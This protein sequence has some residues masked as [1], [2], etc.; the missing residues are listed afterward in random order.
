MI[1]FLAIFALISV[2]GYV[3]CSPT[4]KPLGLPLFSLCKI[5]PEGSTS[6]SVV[7]SI[8]CFDNHFIDVSILQIVSIIARLVKTKPLR[9]SINDLYRFE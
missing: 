9:M 3:S 8:G 4:N 2:T 5:V 7:S 1:N 6:C